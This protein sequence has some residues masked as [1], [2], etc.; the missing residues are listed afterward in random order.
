MTDAKALAA[1][2]D[3]A[4][5]YLARK[6]VYAT[7]AAACIRALT[8]IGT[9]TALHALE[10]FADDPRLT[11]INELEKGWDYFDARLYAEHILSHTYYAKRAN[12]KPYKLTTLT[13]FEYFKGLISLDL[14]EYPLV[15]DLSPL[16]GLTQLTRLNLGE[17]M[18]LTDLSP[19]AGL[20]QLTRLNLN[21]CRGVFD[22]SLLAK[23]TQLTELNLSNCRQVTSLIPLA[24]LTQLIAL[25]LAECMGL[26]DLSPLAGLT[27]I[28]TL[29][30]GRCRQITDLGPLGGLTRLTALNLF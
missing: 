16:A 21:N 30:L 22:L 17:C 20:T 7:T 11:V 26:N 23:L 13:G 24:G 6:Q 15:T 2:G 4:V 5:P 3:V 1:A 14:T 29:N 25:N 27:Q 9:D 19:L 8:L 12:W 28:T 18:E 10:V